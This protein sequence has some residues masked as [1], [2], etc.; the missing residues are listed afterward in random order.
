[1]RFVTESYRRHD[2]EPPAP[3]SRLYPLVESLIE[4]GLVRLW[5][6]TPHRGEDPEGVIGIAHDGRTAGYWLGGSVPG[7]AMTVLL[8]TVL[9]QL[10]K[11]GY[12][13]FDFVG[14]NTPS[15]AVF[16]RQFG[17][18]LTTYYYLEIITR[19]ELRLLRRLKGP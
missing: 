10:Q 16:K 17:G 19:P 7:P 2:R 18:D 15:I 11:E 8:G 9:T 14:A 3:P 13:L 1:V 4:H 12:A 5:T 6:A